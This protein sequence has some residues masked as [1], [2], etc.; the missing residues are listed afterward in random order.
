MNKENT[1]T[2]VII[3]GSGISGL[4]L[5]NRLKENVTQLSF[6]IFKIYDLKYTSHES[7][8][9]TQIMIMKGNQND[10]GAQKRLCA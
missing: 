10:M 6:T 4:I 2:D 3:V 1:N 9:K 5:S 7:I 8:I